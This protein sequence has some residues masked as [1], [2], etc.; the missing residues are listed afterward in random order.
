M[1]MFP[2]ATF[3]SRDCTIP[4]QLPGTNIV[5]EKDQ[6]VIIPVPALQNDPRIYPQPHIFDPDRFQDNNHKP[7]ATYL[8]FGDGPRICIGKQPFADT[9]FRTFKIIEMQENCTVFA[10]NNWD[11]VT[12]SPREILAEYAQG[13]CKVI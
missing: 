11:C 8:P 1:R 5:L 3:L 12:T 7:S 4:Y 10:Y 6:R 2:I 9:R 13:L